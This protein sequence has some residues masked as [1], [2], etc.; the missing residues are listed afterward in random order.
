MLELDIADDGVATLAL[1]RPEALNALSGPLIDALLSALADIQANPDARVLL[2]TGRGRAFCAGADLRDPMMGL[3]LPPTERGRRFLQS[4]D[5]GVHAL[6]RALAHLGKPRV[7]AVNGPA[8]G[9][10]ASLALA[11]DIVLVARSAYFQ[12]PFTAQLGLVPD[13][14][15]SWQLMRR[16]G[17]ARAMG[18]TLLGER[19]S[20]EQAEA[21][22]LVWQ[23]VADEALADAARSIARRL[24]ASAPRALAELPGVMAA[25]LHNDFDAQLDCER[26]AQARLV[27]T[28]DFME[29]VSAFKDKRPPAFSG[30]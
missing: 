4:A 6:A 18:A 29:A 5:Q 26:D 13:M 28:E 3:D 1:N 30:R 9:G 16:L 2:L 25:A 27:Q 24:A 7:A 20:G 22:G 23:C 21:W 11:A 10:G 12:Q 19:I 17:P 14:G 8:V 15:G